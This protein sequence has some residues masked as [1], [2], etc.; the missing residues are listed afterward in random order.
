MILRKHIS[1]KIFRQ[2]YIETGIIFVFEFIMIRQV[3]WVFFQ[4]VCVFLY[5]S[6]LRLSRR[7]FKCSYWS[8]IYQGDVLSRNVQ[9]ERVFTKTIYFQEMLKLK[10]YLPKVCVSKKY[11]NWTWDCPRSVM[12]IAMDY[13][14]VVSEFILQSRYCVHFRANTFGKGMNPLIIPAMG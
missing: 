5:T 10:F 13:G 11:S 4:R 2:E 1:S 9:T 6:D 14:I 3:C 7:I 8:S 12:T